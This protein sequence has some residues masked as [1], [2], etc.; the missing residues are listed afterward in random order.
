MTQEPFGWLRPLRRAAAVIAT[1]IL[2]STLG[3]VA[4][5]LPVQ[6]QSCSGSSC[7]GKDPNAQG[8]DRSPSATDVSE[9]RYFHRYGS[10]GRAL[11]GISLRQSNNS[12]RAVWA[13]A[14]IDA[15]STVNGPSTYRV[16]RLQIRVQRQIRSGTDWTSTRTYSRTIECCATGT[17][18]TNMVQRSGGV[19]QRHRECRRFYIW[20][21]VRGERYWEGWSCGNWHQSYA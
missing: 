21:Y 2:V 20:H 9:P 13:R 7:N 18:W 3:L 10:G 17:F 1:A 11:M 4:S 6:A 14:T 19:Q 12:C 16:E 8:C 5:P 15:W